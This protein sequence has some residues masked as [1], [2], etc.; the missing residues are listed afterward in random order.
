MASPSVRGGSG[1]KSDENLYMYVGPITVSYFPCMQAFTVKSRVA[2]EVWPIYLH[3][4]GY[5]LRACDTTHTPVAALRNARKGI[6]VLCLCGKKAYTE[7]RKGS[8]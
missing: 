4:G 5:I 2:M 8:R 6:S 7:Y 3:G 1:S